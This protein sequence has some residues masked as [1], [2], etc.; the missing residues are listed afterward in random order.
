MNND[1]KN[2]DPIVGY[3]KNSNDVVLIYKNREEKLVRFSQAIIDI[4]SELLGAIE[5][6]ETVDPV[7]M[8]KFHQKFDFFRGAL[9]IVGKV[10]NDEDNASD[11]S[12]LSLPNSKE[13]SFNHKKEKNPK[14]KISNFKAK[15]LKKIEKILFIDITK[16]NYT[17]I[18]LDLHSKIH[19]VENFLI[20]FVNLKNSKFFVFFL[21]IYNFFFIDIFCSYAFLGWFVLKR[22]GN[23]LCSTSRYNQFC[24]YIIIII[25]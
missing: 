23:I 8:T 24:L 18:C 16:F 10:V 4:T 15:K 9:P 1:L 6:N 12:S 13:N 11:E 2:S 25:K 7:F 5:T 14:K 17:Q 22:M 19:E 20:E 21:L 3:T